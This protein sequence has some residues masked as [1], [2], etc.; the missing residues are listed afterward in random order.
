MNKYRYIMYR[1]PRLGTAINFKRVFKAQ[2]GPRKVLYCKIVLTY[3][4][5]NV[6]YFCAYLTA[7]F[8]HIHCSW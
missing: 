3:A 7:V 1:P 2:D 5:Q 8:V 6:S 4:H